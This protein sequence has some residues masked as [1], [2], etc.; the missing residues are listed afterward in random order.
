[1]EKRLAELNVQVIDW[2]KQFKRSLDALKIQ[3]E[4]A[5]GLHASAQVAAPL[6]R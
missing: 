3:N 6:K 1:M 4:E 2:I 5:L